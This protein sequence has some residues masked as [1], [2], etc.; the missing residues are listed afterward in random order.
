MLKLR[1][2]LLLT[3]L[4]AAFVLSAC[5]PTY[6]WRE[7]RGADAPYHVMLPGKPASA[8]RPVTLDGKQVTMSMTAV[9]VKGATFAVGSAELADAAQAR[10]AIVAMKN[11]MVANI[12]GTVRQEKRS[13][14]ADAPEE[15][16]IEAVGAPGAT[17]H[18]RTQ[19]L[20]ARFI[21]RDKRVYQVVAIGAEEAT[22]REVVDTFLSS[23][24]TD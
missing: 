20:F 14:P 5:D 4:C 22:S 11:A 24:R 17:A 15:I 9:E 18:P 21:A 6:N 7:V 19:L 2:T 8:S 12:R 13:G 3:S 10:G 16:A 1:P 23:F